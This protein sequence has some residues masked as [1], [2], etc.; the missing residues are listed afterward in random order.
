MSDSKD[1]LGLSVNI[2]DSVVFTDLDDGTGVLLELDSKVY[3]SLNETGTF[4]WQECEDK[5]K[6]SVHALIERVCEEFEVETS[7]ATDDVEGFIASL[8]DQ[9]LISL[10]GAGA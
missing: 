3:F 8:V 5:E 9:K 7:R 1:Q 2:A 6:V 4:L 10:E